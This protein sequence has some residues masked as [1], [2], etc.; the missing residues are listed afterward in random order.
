MERKIIKG[1]RKLAEALGIHRNTLTKWKKLGFLEYGTIA[2]T[3]RIFLYDFDRVLEGIQ[4]E[5]LTLRRGKKKK[6]TY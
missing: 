1:D 5:T 3:G 2:A 6:L 4:R